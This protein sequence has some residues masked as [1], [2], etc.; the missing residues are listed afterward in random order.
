M[1]RWRLLVVAAALAGSAHPL[2]RLGA[3]G[4]D[5]RIEFEDASLRVQRITINPGDSLAAA[6]RRDGVL[7]YLTADLDGRMPRAEAAWQPG[8]QPMANRAATRFE[9]L[10]VELKAPPSSGPA[11]MPPELAS[12]NASGYEYAERGDHTAVSLVDNDRVI[13]TRHR[14]APL[15]WTER[16]HAH[17]RESVFVY[18]RGGQLTGASALDGYHHARRGAFDVLPAEFWHA[19][20]NG[21][22]D[23]IEFVAIWPK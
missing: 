10:L 2:A 22:N 7:I 11:P 23:P 8:A 16:Y 21:G 17:P 4:D 6:D 12:A 1:S 14:M 20:Y 18:L 3:A 15:R 13:V 19:L 5:R 9:G